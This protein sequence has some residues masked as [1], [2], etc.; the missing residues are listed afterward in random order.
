ME[1]RQ[2]DMNKGIDL[3]RLLLGILTLIASAIQSSLSARREGE[4]GES[5]YLNIK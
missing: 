3:L 2:K 5:K 4:E 1:Q